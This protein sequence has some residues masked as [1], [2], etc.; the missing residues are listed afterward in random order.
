MT[1]RERMSDEIMQKRIKIPISNNMFHNKSPT[2]EALFLPFCSTLPQLH[3]NNDEPER[4]G[5][6]SLIYYRRREYNAIVY[7]Y[8]LEITSFM[9]T[10]QTMDER[11]KKQ[12]QKNEK[13]SSNNWRRKPFQS[14]STTQRLFFYFFSLPTRNFYHTWLNSYKK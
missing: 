14:T 6:F 3:H 10:K 9:N 11:G 4:E 2:I 8:H 1:Q 12:K 5:P 7:C 13:H